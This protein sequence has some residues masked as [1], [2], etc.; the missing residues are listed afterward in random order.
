MCIPNSRLSD[1]DADTHL[2][3]LSPSTVYTIE[4]FHRNNIGNDSGVFFSLLNYNIR[5]FF[6]NYDHFVAMLESL[7]YVPSVITLSET[8][9]TR[10]DFNF[11][12]IDGYEA[13]HTLRLTGKSGGISV[14]YKPTLN[15]QVL[16][17]FSISNEC[18]ESVSIKYSVR[19]IVY[20]VI[21]IYRPH[22]GTI[23]DFC[24]ALD[25]LLSKISNINSVRVIITGDININI[26]HTSCPR[27]I[28]FCNNLRSYFFVP[29]VTN[30][31][32]V[33]KID[34]VEPS[35]LDHI[36]INFIDEQ[37]N[38]GVILTDNSDHYP[39]FMNL[40][41]PHN[42]HSEFIT[43]KFRD[44][45]DGCV[46]LFREK[47]ES[48]DFYSEND[49]INV[50]FNSFNQCIQEA[51]ESCF[52]LRTKLVSSKVLQK[53]WM[54]TAIRNSIRKKS[55]YYKLFKQKIITKERNDEYKNILN[56]TI[57]AAKRRYF[58]SY[59][60]TNMKN[61]RK[62]WEGINTLIG[63]RANQNKSIKILKNNDTVLTDKKAISESFSAYFS[64]IAR[65][66]DGKLPQSTEN[67]LSH[68]IHNA[69]CFFLFPVTE[70]ECYKII[71]NLNNTSY[72]LNNLSTK[73]LKRV[74]DIISYPVSKLINDSFKE[75][76]VPDSLKVACITP[77]FKSGDKQCTSNYRPISV[78][79][80]FSKVFERC[81][82]ERLLNF[83]TKCNII[84]QQQFGFQKGLSCS[85]AISKLLEY[86]YSAINEKK[87][88]ISVF[89]DLKKA[90]DT[91]NHEI[92]LKKLEAY[93][94]RGV[95]LDWFKSYLSNREQ[96]VRIDDCK[97]EYRNIDIGVPQG[98]VLGGLLF[99]IYINDLPSVSDK[100]ISVL[101]ADDTCVSL[102]DIDYTN[103]INDFNTELIK[104]HSWLNSNRLSLN[105]AKTVAIN[106][107]TRTEPY[108]VNV[109][110]ILNGINVKFSNSVKYLGITL[111]NKLTFGDHV[112][113][114]NKKIAKNCGILYRLSHNA[115]KRILVCLYYAL[116]YPYLTYCNPIWGGASDV[117]LNKLLLIQ[118]KTVRAITKSSYREHSDPL[119]YDLGIL[120]V[121]DIYKLNCCCIANKQKEQFPHARS[122]YN[123][124]SKGNLHVSFQRLTVTQRSLKFNVPTHFN[125][126]PLNLKS[127]TLLRPFKRALKT[128]LLSHYL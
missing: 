125:A 13:A 27:V 113:D 83:I 85:D 32:R 102:S 64:S 21:A 56:K 59:F 31:T 96:C 71:N 43:I 5:S 6:T 10:S 2:S 8:W 62:T 30:V 75:G 9:L 69:K 33:S 7:E 55:T 120:K 45:S 28:N 82:Y 44:Q 47:L 65:D 99:L 17:D 42:N 72:G 46:Q 66:L 126:L 104:L 39:V 78:L 86:I 110:L 106:F 77:I 123:T 1:I 58:F 97:S 84:T 89:L 29:V 37:V 22:S 79:P 115:P 128:Y 50:K 4:E 114:I 19:G 91:V 53:P 92:L 34:N 24:N 18:I 35:L 61:I 51:Y 108:N 103:L 116:I 105:L 109:P 67:P 48:M 36:W 63:K 14:F 26:L 88:V 95:T 101:F 117:H 80:L 68:I 15:A 118:K 52:P 11:A 127:I 38:T 124:R 57:R 40:N 100:L 112:I 25:D 121:H 119:F 73:M 90:Y 60:D 70:S 107:S 3:S 12:N 20:Y 54:T 111:D 41:S 16:D 74:A 94:I 49:H 76:I 98:S 23:P 122:I 87:F 81:V 93:G